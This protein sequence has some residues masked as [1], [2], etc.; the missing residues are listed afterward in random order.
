MPDADVALEVING[1]S[2]LT[3][4]WLRIPRVALI[5]HIHRAHYADDSG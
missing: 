5:H 1:I 3:P 4:L 2:F